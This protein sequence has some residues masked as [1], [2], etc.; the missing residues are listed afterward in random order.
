MGDLLAEARSALD[1]PDFRA[2]IEPLIR[3]REA[4]ERSVV[5]DEA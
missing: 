2:K 1:N 3:F 4:L 5:E